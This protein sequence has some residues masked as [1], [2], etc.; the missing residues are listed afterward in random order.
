M[1]LKTK[2]LVLKKAEFEDWQAMYQNV[3][4]H[5]ETAKYMEWSVTTSQEDAKIRIEKTIEYEKT[6]D[7]Y[8][9]YES[10]NGQAIGFA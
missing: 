7:T 10:K 9:V 5:P 8:L 6:H 1:I 4:S 3:W 2:D